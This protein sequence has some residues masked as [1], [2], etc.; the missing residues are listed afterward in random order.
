L[1]LISAGFDA[2]GL[3][4]INHGFVD[5]DEDDFRWITEEVIRIANTCCKGRV[6]SVL[7]GGYGIKGGTVSA[8][9]LSVAA[10]VRALMKAN[11]EHFTER[12]EVEDVEKMN[13]KKSLG[14]KGRE[15]KR[16]RSKYLRELEDNFL[17]KFG[18]EAQDEKIEEEKEEQVEEEEMS[19]DPEDPEGL[20]GLED[21][22]DPEDSEDISQGSKGQEDQV[23]VD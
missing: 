21:P 4:D 1:I 3:D 17:K 18:E 9:G 8:L 13:L 12:S 5:L 2:H 19:E 6:V 16:S 11:Q 14:E 15:L 22:E 7:E 23:I 10:H 20:E